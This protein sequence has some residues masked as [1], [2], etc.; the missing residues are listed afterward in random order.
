MFR[1]KQSLP[2]PARSTPPPAWDFPAAIRPTRTPARAGC[3][4]CRAARAF[5]ATP[6]PEC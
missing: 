1:R 2:A 4:G 6:T 5:G 3:D